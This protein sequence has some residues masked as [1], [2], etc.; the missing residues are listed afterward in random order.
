MNIRDIARFVEG[1]IIG[2]E[3]LEIQHLGKIEEAGQGD[4]TFL[5]NPKYAKFVETTQA[6]ALLVSKAAVSNLNINSRKSPLTLVVVPDSYRSFLQ[7]IDVFYPP[8]APLQKGIH[9][10]SIIPAS[11]KKGNNIAIGAHV[12]IGERCML[13]DGIAIYPGAVIHDDVVIGDGSVI[14]ANVTIREQCRLGKRVCIHAGTVIGTDGFGF[15]PK[16]DGSYEKIPQRGIVVIDDDVE[17]GSNCCI[18]RATIGET[19]I[20]KGV[21]LDNLIQIAHNVVVGENTVMASQTGISGSTK[22]GEQCA[23]GG[24]VGLAGHLTIPPN[25]RIAAQSGVAKSIAEPGKTWFGSPIREVPGA[26]RIEAAIQHLPELIAEVRSLRIR[27]E[28]LEQQL[29][30][31]NH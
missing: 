21:K 31:K 26:F 24:Q 13:G 25:T 20:K 3:S 30:D 22:V 29:N 28:E 2:D 23:F 4:I 9:Q 27:I 12:V 15:A 6:S 18:D 17:I 7:L 5:A 14:Y 8:V 11:V 16:P 19:R 10:T 1:E